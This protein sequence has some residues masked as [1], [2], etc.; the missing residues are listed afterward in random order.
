MSLSL[1]FVNEPPL[2]NKP[3]SL[4]SPPLQCPKLNK[5][6]GGLIELLRYMCTYLSYNNKCTLGTHNGHNNET[7]NNTDGSFTCS[8]DVG[9]AGNGMTCAGRMKIDVVGF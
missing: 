7:C 9:Y 4:L 8:S 3:P 6:P 1:D 2:S 5:P